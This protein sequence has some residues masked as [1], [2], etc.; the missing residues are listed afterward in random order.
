MKN[1]LTAFSIFTIALGAIAQPINYQGKL[2]DKSG[3]PVNGTKNISLK[4]FDDKIGGKQIYEEAIGQ[5]AV[6]DG[7][8]SFKQVH[9]TLDVNLL[10]NTPKLY[11]RHICRNQQPKHFIVILNH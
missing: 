11:S 3:S 10:R 8:Y 9:P 4:I 1:L 2:S 6:K 7:L 5:T